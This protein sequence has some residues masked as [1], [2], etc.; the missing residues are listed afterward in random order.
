MQICYDVE[1]SSLIENNCVVFKHNLYI[2]G[3]SASNNMQTP[4]I[5]NYTLLCKQG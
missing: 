3:Y 1:I 4:L 2:P 5:R